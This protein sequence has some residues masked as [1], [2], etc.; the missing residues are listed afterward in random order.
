MEQGQ[1]F[2]ISFNSRDQQKADWIAWTLREAGHEVAIRKPMPKSFMV[3]SL[4]AM[5]VTTS[6]LDFGDCVL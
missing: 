2:F 5:L 1:K 3:S 4:L 6:A